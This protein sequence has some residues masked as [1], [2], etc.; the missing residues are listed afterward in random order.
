MRHRLSLWKLLILV[1]PL[2]AACSVLAR[3]VVWSYRYENT[4]CNWFQVEISQQQQVRSAGNG[5]APECE[6]PD[7][8]ADK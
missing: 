8:R 7:D 2:F 4:L 1:R 6:G 3:G 5:L